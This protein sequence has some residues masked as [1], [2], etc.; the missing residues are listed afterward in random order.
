MKCKRI[1]VEDSIPVSGYPPGTSDKLLAYSS[2]YT[3]LHDL[4]SVPVFFGLPIACF[5]FARRFAV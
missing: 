2:I 4:F 5:V 3:A 1:T